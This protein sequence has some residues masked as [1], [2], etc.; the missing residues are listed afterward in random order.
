L[1]AAVSLA[2]AR[3]GLLTRGGALAATV[4]GAAAWAAGWSW[5]AVLLT[6]FFSASLLSR[7]HR[8]AKTARTGAVLEKSGARDAVQVFANGG[9]FAVAAVLA[10]AGSSPRWSPV[11]QALGIGAIGAAAADTFASEV[12]TAVGATPRLVFSGRAVPPG[13]S[14]AVTV[15]GTLASVAGATVVALAALV[16]GWPSSHIAPAIA[17]GVAGAAADTVIGATLQERRHCPRCDAATERLVH[18]CGS[19]TS[20]RGGVPG[21]RNDLV[22]LTSCLVGG[23]VAALLVRF[24]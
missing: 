21:F 10:F 14:G 11:W 9:V 2:A 1:A 15:V 7:W 3:F 16:G 6:F 4:V 23:V 20:R 18:S 5:A 24:Q 13:T 19:S 22:N 8:A 12:G 17:A